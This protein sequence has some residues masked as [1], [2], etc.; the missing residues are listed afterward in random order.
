MAAWRY[1]I[2]LLVLKRNFVSLS[3]HVISS[4]YGL[5]R[6]EPI[7]FKDYLVDTCPSLCD[8]SESCTWI[9]LLLCI[10]TERKQYIPHL[11]IHNWKCLT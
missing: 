9:F 6:Q 8:C 2:S 1:E 3:G 5:L 4:I 11:S 7:S 10:D